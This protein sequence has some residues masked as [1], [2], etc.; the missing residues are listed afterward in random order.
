MGSLLWGSA[1]ALYGVGDIVTTLMGL[2]TAGVNEAHPV[3]ASILGAYGPAG[4]VATKA[5]VIGVAMWA[6]KNVVPREWA[7]GVPVGLSA[8]G[9]LIVMN[10]LSVL[11][12]A[13][14]GA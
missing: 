4:M 8:L 11:A 5:V 6:S 13:S 14:G 1:I 2:Q 9:A 12:R 7:V 3:S 10:N